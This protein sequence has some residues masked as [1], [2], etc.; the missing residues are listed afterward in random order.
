VTA[1]ATRW[2]A[3][4]QILL[5]AAGFLVLVAISTASVVLVNQARKD[6]AWVVHTVE[7]EN[8]I[9]TLQLQVRR[10][11]SAERGY[12]LTAEPRF[13]A[14]YETAAATIMPDVDKLA[15]LT[16]DNPVQMENAKQLRPPAPAI[17]FNA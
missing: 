15:A 8:Q 7:A 16:A 6:N 2:R 3:I 14:E 9:S 17:P 13:L 5:L 4:G 10:A 11:E 1:D 12:L